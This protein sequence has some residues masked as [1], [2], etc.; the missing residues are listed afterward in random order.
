MSKPPRLEYAIS[1]STVF[2]GQDGV[3]TLLIQ[4]KTSAPTTGIDRIMVDFRLNV[5][6][7]ES[8]DLPEVKVV[9]GTGWQIRDH[10]TTAWLLFL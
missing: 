7:W 10:H 1:S 3:V 6:L 9:D 5:P 2:A 8:K 4:N